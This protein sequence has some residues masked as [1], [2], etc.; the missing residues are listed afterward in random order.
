VLA[1]AD[2]RIAA[3]DDLGIRAA[4]I[5]AAGPAVALVARRP[6]GT[7]DQLAAL[8][9]RFVALATPPMASVFVTGRADIAFATGAH[10]VILRKD[11]LDVH[12]VRTILSGAQHGMFVVRSVHSVA[13]A[14]A[15]AREGVDAIIVGAIWPTATHPETPAVGIA[16]LERVVSLGVPTYA[17][18]G[19][20]AERAVD[21]KAAGAWGVA[22]IRAVWDAASPY[23]AALGLAA[24]MTG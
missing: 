7:A 2:D 4:A 10:G 11:D 23:G 8:A 20:T 24:K 17:I 18:G 15:A 1:F 19:I 16:L 22:A 6:A 5:A 9:A 3:I 12:T 13:D 21:A 14:E